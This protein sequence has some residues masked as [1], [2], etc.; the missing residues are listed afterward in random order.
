M[1]L[2]LALI[3]TALFCSVKFAIGFPTA[4]V[5][6]DMNFLESVLFGFASGTLGNLIFIYAGD[7]INRLIDKL[8]RF[9]R[10]N[11]VPKAKKVFTKKNRRFVYIKNKYGLPGLALITPVFISIPVGNFLATRFFHNK[12]KILL[13]MSASVLAWTLVIS[14]IKFAFSN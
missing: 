11:R 3:G 12:K 14:V 9:L 1:G 10:P 6:F 8:I 5:K 13:Y 4:I 2:I 7:L